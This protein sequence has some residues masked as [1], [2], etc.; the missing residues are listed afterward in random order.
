MIV[1]IINNLSNIGEVPAVFPCSWSK[2]KVETDG[3][4]LQNCVVIDQ[5]LL[6]L[7]LNIN[8]SL[9]FHLFKI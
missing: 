6:H 5:F 7:K 8:R 2:K 4:D 1:I 3:F 9:D